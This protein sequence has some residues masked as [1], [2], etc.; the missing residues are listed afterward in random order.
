MYPRVSK[1]INLLNYFFIIDISTRQVTLK[2]RD[3]FKM[4]L[5]GLSPSYKFNPETGT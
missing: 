5:I 4:S 3:L 2:T 1:F